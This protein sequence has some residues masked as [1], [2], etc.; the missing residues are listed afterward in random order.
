MER[1][2][3]YNQILSEI[4]QAKKILVICHEKPDGDT[5]GAAC[6]F[7]NYFDNKNIDYKAFC[8][9][10]VPGIYDFMPKTEKI[11]NEI[12]TEEIKDY[13]LIFAI[14]C[15]ELQRTGIADILS[16]RN[17]KLINIDHHISNNNFGDLNLVE[18]KASSTS[19]IVYEFF[20]EKLLINKN[21]ATCLLTGMLDDT[22]IFSNPGTNFNVIH[23]SADLL[24]KGANTQK[25]IRH[26]YKSRSIESLKFWGEILSRL[27]HNK[28]LNIISTYITR[29]DIERYRLNEDD[30]AAGISNYIKGLS[31]ADIILV[32]KETAD[33]F[34]KGSLRTIKDDI[35]VSKIAAVFGGGGHKKASGFKVKGK[36]KVFEDNWTIS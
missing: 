18:Y 33:G 15:G 13:D 34:V 36:I 8:V 11:G 5:I 9:D 32:L 21:I 22:E 27:H 6:A 12:S 35:D 31:E 23:A 28:E 25:I 1:Q 29:H 24:L 4:E 16:Q 17:S 10:E 3:I 7:L 19:E 30:A 14:D 20:N 26:I 2:K